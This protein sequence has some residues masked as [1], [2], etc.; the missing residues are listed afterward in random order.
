MISQ[1]AWI[2]ASAPP[3]IGERVI[4]AANGFIKTGRTEMV[5]SKE[6]WFVGDDNRVIFGVTVWARL[7]DYPDQ[8]LTGPSG[9]NTSLVSATI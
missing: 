9:V 8:M 3:P 1:I 2:P 5:A 6:P 7:Q 4:I